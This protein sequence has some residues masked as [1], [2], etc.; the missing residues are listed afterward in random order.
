MSKRAVIVGTGEYLQRAPDL[1]QAREPVELMAQALRQAEADS[2][3]RVLETIDSIDLVGLV[4]WRYRDPV[5][6]LCERI[7]IAPDRRTNA[8]MGGETPVRLLHEAALSIARGEIRAAAIVGGE[9]ASSRSKARKGGIELDWTPI[10][11]REETVKFPGSSYRTGKPARALGMLDPANI[12]PFYE[13]ATQAAWNQTPR[14]AHEQSAR[15]WARFAAQA[16]RNPSAWIQRAPDA[17]TIGRPSAENRPIAWPY[18]KLMVANPSVDLAA[19]VIVMDEELARSLGVPD[20]RMIHLLGGAAA[21]EDEDY[22]ARDRYDHSTA[23][24]AVLDAVADI[25][26]GAANFDWLELYSCFPVVPKMAMRHLGLDAET[27]LPTVTGG[28]TFFGGPLNNYMSHAIAAMVRTLREHPGDLGLVY[29]QG[30]YVTKHHALVLSTTPPNAPLGTDYS[31]QAQADEARTPVPA[32][33]ET[34]EGPATIEAYTVTYA[35]DCEPLQGVVIART[36]SGA[37][38]MARVV[39]EDDPATIGVLTSC[40]S[41][42]VGQRGSVRPDVFGKLVFSI[43]EAPTQRRFARTLVERDGHLTVITINRP[44]AM[45]AFDPATNAE[46]AEIFDAFEAD[47]EQWV[48]IVTGAGDRAFSAGNDLKATACL[49]ARGAPIETPLS[50]FGGLTARF[51]L[52]KPVI[53]A[54]NGAAMGGGFEVAL[55]CDII[56]ASESASF[57]LPE[58]KVGLAALAGGLLRLPAQ[59]GQKRAMGL[60]LTGR[61]VSAAEGLE[62]GFVNEVVP[63]ADLLD[64]ARRW[65]DAILQA[66]PMSIRASKQIVQRGAEEP[67]LPAAYHAQNRYP[68]TRALFR[69]HDLQEGPVAFAEKRKPVW[70]GQ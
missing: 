68:A 67:G 9:A 35:A 1:S 49:M 44:E 62:L 40:E 29:G 39:P 5:N 2:G 66:S 16:A 27:T 54:V 15:L 53:A 58:P 46:M 34:Y 22:L 20:D 13:T 42:A 3:A 47:P 52:T 4:S 19:A 48:A 8:S 45:N 25:A 55:A 51:G 38:I 43:G 69:S 65:A 63:Q 30:G 59:I 50:G 17:T 33:L 10:P 14:E 21:A 7:G 56:V 18:P 57:A 24:A 70:K 60:I 31:V 6:L 32:L 26:G 11:S 36:D 12:Y 41:S 23:Q 37:R 64:A 28:L 61:T